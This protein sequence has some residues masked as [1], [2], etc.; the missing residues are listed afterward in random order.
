LYGN[1]LDPRSRISAEWVIFLQRSLRPKRRGRGLPTAF[2][3]HCPRTGRPVFLRAARPKWRP[4]WSLRVSVKATFRL[5]RVRAS[6]ANWI[7]PSQAL[8]N[9]RLAMLLGIALPP[10]HYIVF[11]VFI[12]LDRLRFAVPQKR[13]SLCRR[14]QLPNHLDWAQSLFAGGLAGD[15]VG[16]SCITPSGSAWGAHVLFT[17]H[18]PV[19]QAYSLQMMTSHFR[20]GREAH[21]AQC[22][23][24]ARFPCV[25]A[26]P[27]M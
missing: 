27:S 10:K 23:G 17:A 22:H 6:M 16:D 26:H 4:D 13:P 8:L 14:A 25:I 18:P 2:Y 9:F 7:G 15:V 20:R 21:A 3:V 5:N 12:A 19:R 11:F 1:I 24:V